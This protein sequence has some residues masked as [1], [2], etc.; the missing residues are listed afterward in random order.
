MRGE[1]KYFKDAA[2]YIKENLDKK[3]GGSWNVIVGK[4]FGSYFSYESKCAIFFWINH[5]GFL[6]WKFA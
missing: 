6:I 5:I 4:S 2:V 3:H 1:M